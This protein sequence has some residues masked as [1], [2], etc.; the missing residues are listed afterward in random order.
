[1]NPFAISVHHHLCAQSKLVN[2][3]HLSHVTRDIFSIFYNQEYLE[4]KNVI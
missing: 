1:M 4:K 2:L 3:V